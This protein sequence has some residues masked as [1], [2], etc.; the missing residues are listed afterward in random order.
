MIPAAAPDNQAAVLVSLDFG[1]PAP[2]DAAV[3]LLQLARRAGIGRHAAVRGRRQ[4]P[5]AKF[6]AGSGKV[7]EIG[8]AAAALN[9]GWVIFN[10][11]LSPAQ[12][13]NLEAELKCRVLD[14][15]GLILEIFSQRAQTSEGKLQVEL[16]QLEHL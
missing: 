4:R 15:T 10:H 3:V 16:A 14:R 8:A 13:R 7:A 5:D 9:A 2:Y 1:D 11:N 6:Y 12:E